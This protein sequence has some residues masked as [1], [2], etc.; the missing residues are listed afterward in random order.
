MLHGADKFENCH[1]QDGAVISIS[2]LR[3]NDIRGMSPCDLR[4]S[5][6]Q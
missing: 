1:G 5:G 6:Y 3:N 4:F 2:I